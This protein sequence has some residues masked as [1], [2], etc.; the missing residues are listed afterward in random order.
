M[1]TPLLRSPRTFA[2]TGSAGHH[3]RGRGMKQTILWFLKMYTVYQIS[4]LYIANVLFEA[5]PSL[6]TENYKTSICR[7]CIVSSKHY[8]YKCRGK[9]T[10]LSWYCLSMLLCPPS[11]DIFAHRQASGQPPPPPPRLYYYCMM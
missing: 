11:P 5:I 3:R 6:V 1:N 2:I 7:L 9:G 10:C 8:M 4:C